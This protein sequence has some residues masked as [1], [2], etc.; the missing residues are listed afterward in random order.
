VARSRLA[1]SRDAGGVDLYVSAFKAAAVNGYAAPDRR[2]GGPVCT[3]SGIKEVNGIGVDRSGMLWVPEQDRASGSESI[4]SYAPHCGAPGIVLNDPNGFPFDIAFDSRGTNYVMDIEDFGS[5]PGDVLVFP[6]GATSPAA[7]LT[8]PRLT[9]LTAVGVDREDDLY[10]AYITRAQT[11]A[12]VEFKKGAMPGKPLR[13]FSIAGVPGGTLFFDANRN[14]VV[15]DVTNVT[16]DVYAPPYDRRPRQIPLRGTSWQCV[17]NRPQRDLACADYAKGDVDV[18][19]YPGG[20][21][22]YSITSGLLPV[23]TVVGVAYGPASK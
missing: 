15:D 5:K 13:G 7:T 9:L 23:D 1:A 17:L 21:Y 8:D 16:A 20:T 14:L 3:V 2:D 6:K 4:R 18:Y 12:I 10:V 11:G 19:A 22:L